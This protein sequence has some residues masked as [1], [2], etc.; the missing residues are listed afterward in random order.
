MRRP[1]ADGYGTD[2]RNLERKSAVQMCCDRYG[3]QHQKNEGRFVE[4]HPGGDEIDE[5]ITAQ[6]AWRNILRH[7]DIHRL[8]DLERK[9]L[10]AFSFGKTGWAIPPVVSSRILSCLTDP[11]DVL[12]MFSQET[13]SSGAIQ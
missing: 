11:T 9:S 13:I 2:D 12:S 7:G 6:Q 10:S 5:A 8:E 3:W 4:Y 1:G